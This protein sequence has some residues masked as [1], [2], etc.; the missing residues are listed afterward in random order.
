MCAGEGACE[1]PVVLSQVC[2]VS[3]VP[4]GGPGIGGGK[5]SQRSKTAEVSVSSLPF[6]YPLFFLSLFLI[7][8]Y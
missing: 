6:P 8:L 3:E 2:V 4:Q 1:P 7:I 5:D